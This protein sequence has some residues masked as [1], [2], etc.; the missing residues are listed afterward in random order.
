MVDG[1]K[2]KIVCSRSL[3]KGSLYL[4]RVNKS[5]LNTRHIRN[6]QIVI[7]LIIYINYVVFFTIDY[8]KISAFINCKKS[9]RVSVIHVVVKSNFWDV[10]SNHFSVLIILKL[11]FVK[12]V[13]Y[14]TILEGREKRKRH[15]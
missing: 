1:I 14:T 15:I 5:Q 11:V 2:T 12:Y 3:K 6:K 4:F 7:S 8:V 9:K 10:I 13:S